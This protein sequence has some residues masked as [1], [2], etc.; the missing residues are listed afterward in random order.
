MRV[1]LRLSSLRL[2][3]ALRLCAKPVLE[4]GGYVS[5]KDAKSR[6]D[7]EGSLTALAGF[8]NMTRAA[9]V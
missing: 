4:F 8:V 7:A 3:G 6:K 1:S 2:C 9:Y 5:R